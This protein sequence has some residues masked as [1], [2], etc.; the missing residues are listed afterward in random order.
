MACPGYLVRWTHSGRLECSLPALC[1]P[2][3]R[4][5]N[6][7]VDPWNLALHGTPEYSPK[8][9]G[10]PHSDFWGSF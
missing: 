9:A 5:A 4:V 2:Q 6:C 1:P 10:N 8:D 3:P 7:T